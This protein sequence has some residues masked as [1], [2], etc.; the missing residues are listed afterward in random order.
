MTTDEQPTVIG[1]GWVARTSDVGYAGVPD[2]GAY[3]VPMPALAQRSMAVGD[4]RDARDRR[5]AE[6]DARDRWQA[7]LIMGRQPRSVAE[8]LAFAERKGRAADVIDA[9]HHDEALAA[10]GDPALAVPAPRRHATVVE[11]AVVR[12]HRDQSADP[13]M[14]RMI[15]EHDARV[16]RQAAAEL[17]RLRIDAE[18]RVAGM[19]ADR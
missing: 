13:F 7:A 8:V 17:R 2:G 1:A 6:D 11:D 19:G 4:A 16:T 5:Q 18:D 15:S 9:R 14:S 3:A 10:L 12:R